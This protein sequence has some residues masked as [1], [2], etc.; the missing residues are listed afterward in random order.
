MADGDA[1][2]IGAQNAGADLTVLNVADREFA[3]GL[4]VVAPGVNGGPEAESAAIIGR[5]P[6]YRKGVLGIGQPGVRGQASNGSGDGVSGFSPS[7]LGVVGH[8]NTGNGVQGRGN[9][10]VVAFHSSNQHAAYLATDCCGAWINGDSVIDGALSVSGKLLKGGGGFLIDHPLAPADRYLAHSFVESSEMK[11]IYDG[12]AVLDDNGEAV[13]T[14]PEWFESVNSNV[15]Y[16]LT[17]VG[18]PAPDL[19]V[20]E[21]VIERHFKLAGGQPGMKV[22]WQLTAVR[23]DPWARANPMEVEAD[24]TPEERGYFLN[25][26]LHGHGPDKHIAVLTKPS[27]ITPRDA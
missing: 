10:G 7:G 27:V 24:K 4:E 18:D 11:N 6:D 25:P 13:V 9:G 5:S 26:E 16:Q 19:H 15:R 3:V 2:I 1:L 22:C 23:A 12:I 14:L 20:A 21:E 17:P 8:S